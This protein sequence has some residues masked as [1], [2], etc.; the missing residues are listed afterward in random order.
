[1]LEAGNQEKIFTP[2]IGRGVKFFVNGRPADETLLA[3][4]KKYKKSRR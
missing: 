1:M 2:L 4:N 3:I